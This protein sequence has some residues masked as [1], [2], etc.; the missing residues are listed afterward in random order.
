MY[1]KKKEKSEFDHR[2]V[3]LARVARITEGGRRFS[4]RALIVLGNKKGKVGIGLAK[5]KD[6]ASAI[7]KGINQAKTRL[8]SVPMYKGTLPFEVESKFKMVNIILRPLFHGKGIIAG[9]VAR[10]ICELAGFENINIKI[11]SKSKNKINNAKAVLSG[12]KKIN[13][14]LKVKEKYAITSNTNKK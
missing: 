10:D 4:F 12:F 14:I 1:H 7:N 5:A 8:I 9:G 11:L 2:L 3:D 6:V 13:E